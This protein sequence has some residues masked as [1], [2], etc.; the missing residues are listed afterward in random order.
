MPLASAAAWKGPF[1][2]RSRRLLA[3][4][5]GGGI[6]TLVGPKWPETVFEIFAWSC[7]PVAKP[8]A[9]PEGSTCGRHDERP[10]QAAP[11]SGVRSV[12]SDHVHVARRALFPFGA[13]ALLL[14]LG[15]G[16]G[17]RDDSTSLAPVSQVKTARPELAFF[18]ARPTHALA[19]YD[20]GAADDR[21]D[22]LRVVTGESIPGTVFPQLF[23]GVSWS[24]DGRRVAFAG[25]K[26]R[27]TDEHNEPTDIYAI[28]AD[29]S[30]TEQITDIGDAYGPLW[31]PDRKTIVFTRRS[32]GEG[33]PIRG[34]LWSVGVDGSGLAEIAAADDWE[35]FTA[36]SFTADGSQLAV[37]RITFDPES[38]QGSSEIELM[39][40]DG[41]DQEQLIEQASDPAF[42]PDGKRIA[43]VSD[44]DRNGRLCYGDSCS[45][46][47]ELYVANADGSDPKRLTETNELNEAHPSWL[48]DGS[49]IAY[50][51]GEVFQN[52]EATSI[53]EINPDGSC[54]RQV[55]AGSGPG[56][57]YANPAWRP[58]KPR[59][60]GGALIC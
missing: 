20:L 12:I 4:S 29:G 44:R 42:S 8:E 46:G 23:T 55:L 11:W 18:T 16:G 57:W 50:H 5:G 54:G 17:D 51:Q 14:A 59:E 7:L 45:Y 22:H 9:S 60:G 19:I 21:G 32:D 30:D 38:F 31:S 33:D 40:P 49:R 28:D 13:M 37:T 39:N 56:A 36:G 15:C 35:T 48:P 47:S 41:S 24:P 58:S 6:R 3:F 53:L 43:F 34:S 25:V 27:Q 26:G 1:S 10:A 52:A 2:P